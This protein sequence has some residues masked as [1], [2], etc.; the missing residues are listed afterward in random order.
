MTAEN[1]LS[2]DEIVELVVDSED[3]DTPWHPTQ[4]A[5]IT[6]ALKELRQRREDERVANTLASAEVRPSKDVALE[7]FYAR[8]RR[9]WAEAEAAYERWFVVPPTDKWHKT[10]WLAGYVSA[11]QD[12]VT[13]SE[14]AAKPPEDSGLLMRA[15]VLI[16]QAAGLSNRRVLVANGVER[17]V[18]DGMRQWLVDFALGLSEKATEKRAYYETHEGPHCPTCYCGEYVDL[19]AEKT[20]TCQHDMTKPG[21]TLTVHHDMRTEYASVAECRACGAR[22]NH[23]LHPD[24]RKCEPDDHMYVAAGGSK[25]GTGTCIKCGEPELPESENG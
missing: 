7:S 12:R 3:L 23:P 5:K 25:I 6:L 18:H 10:T 24:P 13:A 4:L 15:H 9:L 8:R 1:Q 22:F 14:T 2:Y 17:E 21:H 11:L 19:P 16:C 20:E